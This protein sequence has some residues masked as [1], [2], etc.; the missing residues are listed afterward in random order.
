MIGSFIQRSNFLLL[1]RPVINIKYVESKP[2]LYYEESLKY[3]F[4]VKN[5]FELYSNIYQ[6]DYYYHIF[7]TL[8]LNAVNLKSCKYIKIIPTWNPNIYK[9]LYEFDFYTDTIKNFKQ[10]QDILFQYFYN[11][12]KYI[13]KKNSSLIDIE[14]NLYYFS[15]NEKKFVF[16]DSYNENVKILTEAI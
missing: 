15:V 5:S 2:S 6:Q 14:M 1:S 12:R 13:L 4:T 11:P 8:I 10:D 7:D 9:N 16:T 3:N